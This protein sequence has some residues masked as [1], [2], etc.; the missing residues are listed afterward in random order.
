MPPT[1]ILTDKP[2]T[3]PPESDHS[4][5]TTT[6]L[7]PSN[8]TPPPP[9]PSTPPHPP[10]EEGDPL[11]A[12]TLHTPIPTT[13]SAA[14]GHG[15][16]P[17]LTP[18][19][20]GTDPPRSDPTSPHV[21]PDPRGSVLEECEEIDRTDIEDTE[22]SDRRLTFARE[23][24]ERRLV[25]LHRNNPSVPLTYPLT[26]PPVEAAP[27]TGTPVP[28]P[29]TPP[30]AP[31]TLHNST[32]GKKGKKGKRQAQPEE[33]SSSTA[34]TSHPVPPAVQI[35]PSPAKPSAWVK[36]PVLILTPKVTP[37]PGPPGPTQ[38]LPG[39]PNPT[40]DRGSPTTEKK[41]IPQSPRKG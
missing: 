14:N 23:L 40:S 4:D 13:G 41:G 1:G 8:L 29:S 36:P 2:P 20:E 27:L 34:T 7:T 30:L 15:N 12:H 26:Q 17:T 5:P 31:L 9:P 3:V 21:P 10:L 37:N 16:S 19:T 33:P 35:P 39:D 11:Q 32:T 6:P 28:P 38:V 24:R 22:S 18:P 25:T